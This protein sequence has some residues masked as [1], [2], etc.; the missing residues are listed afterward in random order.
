MQRY[1]YSSFVRS[2]SCTA[3]RVVGRGKPRKG[4]KAE[5]VEEKKKKKK[6]EVCLTVCRH[7][8]LTAHSVRSLAR[9]FV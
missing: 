9:S 4:R 6:E 2:F 3:F 5:E 8:A 1:T 7:A